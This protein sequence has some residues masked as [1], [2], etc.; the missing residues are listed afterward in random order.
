MFCF[1]SLV[2]QV[3]YKNTI[4]KLPDEETYLNKKLITSTK[5]MA[6]NHKH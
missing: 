1:L 3:T 5:I 6:S 4:S 2:L